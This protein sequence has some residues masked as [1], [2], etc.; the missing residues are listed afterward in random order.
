[1]QELQTK[2]KTLELDAQKINDQA[3]Q[4]KLEACK[5]KCDELNAILNPHE[6]ADLPKINPVLATLTELLNS[7]NE[8]QAQ[9]LQ[10]REQCE[11]HIA[12]KILTCTAAILGLA[13]G[14]TLA[15]ALPFFGI[16]TLIIGLGTVA[17]ASGATALTFGGGGFLV[18]LAATF[19]GVWHER[20]SLEINNHIQQECYALTDSLHDSI[21][22]TISADERLKAHIQNYETDQD[23]DNYAR[24]MISD[25]NSIY[26]PTHDF[27]LL[28]EKLKKYLDLRDV[29]YYLARFQNSDYLNVLT[30]EREKT[31]LHPESLKK[32]IAEGNEITNQLKLIDGLKYKFTG[33]ICTADFYRQNKDNNNAD[34]KECTVTCPDT[35]SRG[36]KPF[37]FPATPG[38]TFVKTTLSTLSPLQKE[39]AVL[40][41]WNILNGHLYSDQ[42]VGINPKTISLQRF[43][44]GI[45][46][47]IPF[48]ELSGLSLQFPGYIEKKSLTLEE[49]NIAA[50]RRFLTD[51][52]VR[53]ICITS[54]PL[55]WEQENWAKENGLSIIT[56]CLRGDQ[57]IEGKPLEISLQDFNNGVRLDVP[58]H[59]LCGLR[60]T[61]IDENCRAPTIDALS[62]AT[63]RMFINDD[64]RK[65]LLRK[66]ANSQTDHPGRNAPISLIK[67]DA[68]EDCDEAAN[69]NVGEISLHTNETDD[70][71][72][73]TLPRVSGHRNDLIVITY[74]MGSGPMDYAHACRHFHL[75]KFNDLGD[76][77]HPVD[78][79]NEILADVSNPFA[80]QYLLAQARTTAFFVDLAQ[81]NEV[82]V[83]LIQ[84][85]RM[86][87]KSQGTF[88]EAL[89]KE[90]FAYYSY[91]KK[92]SNAAV[93][94]RKE[95]FGNHIMVGT[96]NSAQDLTVVIAEDSMTN[97]VIS[98]S[99]ISVP[100]FDLAK[101]ELTR[102]DFFSGD[103][104]ISDAI[105]NS[106]PDNVKIDINLI[107]ADMNSPAELS[108]LMRRFTDLSAAGYERLSTNQTTDVYYR[109]GQESFPQRNLDY[110]FIKSTHRDYQCKP[111]E[112]VFEYKV[113]PDKTLNHVSDH[114]PVRTTISLTAFNPALLEI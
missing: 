42:S 70:T 99:S 36:I 9:A 62:I 43:S 20:G 6:L 30:R 113:E 12:V 73:L 51:D 108:P 60:V 112:V 27:S 19:F 14:I 13:V 56:D 98:F 59:Q 72:P 50:Q 85:G 39:W 102:E 89:I 76:Q 84:E 15:I 104:R 69:E 16:P 111:A 93:L 32:M 77:E 61:G 92:T 65:I 90:G 44:N 71:S 33:A 40:E 55:S 46:I 7:V 35:S 109:E 48:N 83:I 2:L 57:S 87:D 29:K 45:A 97:Q 106:N 24:Q 41:G 107:G 58:L 34:F 5:T 82:D 17:G 81:R 79:S 52:E 53:D 3:F 21:A 114:L 25:I 86:P 105:N 78:L 26:S 103:G 4:T 10:L 110:L 80:Q 94:M 91:G 8:I 37:L 67:I 101:E 66:I 75:D 47:G 38:I 63:Q 11:P 18:G 95:R 96:R 22:L 23:T 74:N 64:E 100:G 1:M 49:F 31:F 88:I 68:S 54:S 28:T